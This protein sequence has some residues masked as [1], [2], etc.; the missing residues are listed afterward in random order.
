MDYGLLDRTGRCSATR[1]TTATRR[2][3]GVVEQVH[4]RGPGGELYAVTGIQ[5]LPFNTIYQLR[6]RAARRSCAARATLLLIPDLLAYWLTGEI[7]AEITNASTTGCS[8]C[9]HRAWATR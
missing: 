1:C 7:G 5:L 2:T 6:G 4:G 9:R 3:D 8:T